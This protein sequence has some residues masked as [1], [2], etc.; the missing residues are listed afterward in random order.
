VT[1][2]TYKRGQVEWALWRICSLSHRQ[3]DTEPSQIFRTRIKRLLDVDRT[4]ESSN[5]NI[6]PGAAH[7]FGKIELGG[8]GVETPYTAEDAFSLAIALDLLNVGFKQSEV[9]F[10]IRHVRDLL[11][12]VFPLAAASTRDFARLP[13]ARESSC[14]QVPDNRVFLVL[15]SV[16]LTDI[17]PFEERL[18]DGELL[19]LATHVC[20]GLSALIEY[21][22]LSAK[23]HQRTAVTV[24][25]ASTAKA[26]IRFLAEAPLA[27]RGRP[28]RYRSSD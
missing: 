3:A 2:R 23:H 16:E 24:E 20:S 13:A 26:L 14:N 4:F 27:P 12:D 15:A 7:A 11:N 17:V 19:Y 6:D 21:L 9:V 25:I 8:R 10:V 28:S 22:D 5:I 18:A 1:S